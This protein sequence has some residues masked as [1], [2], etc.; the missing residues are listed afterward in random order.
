[1]TNESDS[2]TTRALNFTLKFYGLKK[3]LVNY[4]ALKSWLIK[5]ID[6]NEKELKYLNALL[7]ML[8][9]VENAIVESD[10]DDS[11]SDDCSIKTGD[12]QLLDEDSD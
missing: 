9:H 10:S 7:I 12:I 3:P 8:T 6:Q 4:M 5:K 2:I 1:M 11:D